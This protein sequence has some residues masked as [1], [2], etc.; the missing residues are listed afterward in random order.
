MSADSKA[1][2]RMRTEAYK[3]LDAQEDL[4]CPGFDSSRVFALTAQYLRNPPAGFPS[5]KRLG[6]S[7]QSI[8]LFVI[9]PQ[10]IIDA[11]NPRTRPTSGQVSTSG[12]ALRPALWYVDMKNKMHIGR[13]HPP[14][15]V[16]GRKRKPDVIVECRDRDFVDLATGKAH[17]QT[18][19]NQG[20]V[21]F[22]P[23]HLPF[24]ADD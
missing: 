20:R 4:A 9:Q 11:S 13:G 5:R 1:D 2:E 24:N 21:R 8:Y 23:V 14:K 18:L 22:S 17:P 15:T 12:G 3:A 6:R 16:L 10:T 7:L 19:Y